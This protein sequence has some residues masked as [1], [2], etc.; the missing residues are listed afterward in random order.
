MINSDKNY[1]IFVLRG[2]LGYDCAPTLEYAVREW[3][4]GCGCNVGEGI[5]NDTHGGCSAV[6]RRTMGVAVVA[7]GKAADD[8]YFGFEFFELTNDF[9]GYALTIGR[10]MACTHKSH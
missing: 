3:L 1:D 4:I 8:G 5:G 9:G 7:E 2:Y 6:E 10:H